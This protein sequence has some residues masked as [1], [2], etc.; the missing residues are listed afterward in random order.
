MHIDNA[1]VAT[2]DVWCFAVVMCRAIVERVVDVCCRKGG[3]EVN[4]EDIIAAQT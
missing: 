2:Y 4:A 3:D 1:G